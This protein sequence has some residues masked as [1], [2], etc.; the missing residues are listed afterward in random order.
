MRN[1]HRHP[2]P[3]PA[4]VPV[5]AAAEDAPAHLFTVHPNGVS[6]VPLTQGYSKNEDG[7]TKKEFQLIRTKGATS[8]VH[9]AGRP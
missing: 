1:F 9:K 6:M 5:G 8:R 3:G 4:G 2:E 7:T